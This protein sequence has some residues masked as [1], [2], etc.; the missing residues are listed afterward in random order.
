MDSEEKQ[1]FVTIDLSR[2][3]VDW[4][5][6]K[7]NE[8]NGKTY[9][10]VYAPEGGVFFYPVESIKDYRDNPDRVYFVRPEGTELTVHYSS[11]VAGVPDTAP[12]EEK[13]HSFSKT[14]KIEDL[15][16]MYDEERRAFAEKK[17]AEREQN[18]A[19]WV[20]YTVPTSWGTA[21]SSEKGNFVSLSVPID[22][23]YY[24]FILQQE[25]FKES[26]KE[27]GK[28]YFSFPR[29]QR[30]NPEEDYKVQLK[31]GERQEDGSYKDTFISVTS[32]ALKVY[33]DAALKSKELNEMFV[34]VDISERLIRGFNSKDGREFAEVSVPV[35]EGGSDKAEF[36]KIVVQS[37]RI[38]DGNREGQKYLS[39]FVNGP[40]GEE[41]GFDAKKSIRDEDGNWSEEVKR[42]TSREVVAAFKESAERYRNQRASEDQRPK[43]DAPDANAAP[44][45]ENQRRAKRGGR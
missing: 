32:V 25:R 13:Y 12:N 24:S 31:R 23:S 44:A 19:E 35:Y 33:I 37:Q 22:G 27:E 16:E 2:K 43:K 38:M 15:K 4:E 41:Y 36:Y 14:I 34:G 6:A 8:K 9:A 17:Q 42:M 7:V 45:E 29:M 11:R 18:A 3:Q 1:K 40:D 28:S 5:H 20:S 21:F 10:R 30:D 39:L 26:A